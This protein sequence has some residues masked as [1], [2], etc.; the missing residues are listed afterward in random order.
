MGNNNINMSSNINGMN[1]NNFSNNPML[2]ANRN[3]LI[4]NQKKLDFNF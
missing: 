2:N 3:Y 1:N 4:Q